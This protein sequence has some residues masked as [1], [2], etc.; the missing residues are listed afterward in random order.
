MSLISLNLQ[1]P[2]RR[3]NPLENPT[4]P[5]GSHLG[6]GFLSGYREDDSGELVNPATAMGQATINSCVR[7]ISETIASMSPI[8]YERSGN[9]KVEA[10][11]NPLHKILTLEPSPDCSAFSMWDSFVAS[12]ALWGNGYLEIQRDGTGTILGLHFLPPTSVTPVRQPDKTIAYRVTLGMAEGTFRLLPAKSIC[13]VPWHS[14]DGV[15]GISV[16]AQARN[17]IGSAIAM[18]KYSG[19]FWANDAT[20]SGVL[21]SSAKIKPEDKLKMRSD[22][23]ALNSGANQHKIAILDSDLTYQAIGIPNADSEWIANMRLSR[24]SICGLFK[25]NPSQIGDTAR[26]AGE[27]YGAQQLA[28]LTHTLRPWLNRIQQELTRKLIPGLPQYSIEHNVSDLLRLDFKSQ[29]D[30][31]AVA[32]QWGIL[33]SNE[34]REQL[35]LDPGPAECDT[36]W[37][38]ANMLDAQRLLN[39]PV[40]T[41]VEGT[42]NV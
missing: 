35:G 38:P 9:G 3:S 25:V 31:F 12:I 2:E 33:T 20:P 22:W 13:H 30:S 23:G 24:E 37:S 8:L 18:D 36:F 17:V 26:V 15:S 7:L 10:F 16:I 6:W 14:V 42:E 32:R 19:R 21:K 29:M 4:V 40:P 27:T 28:W 39:P 41:V 11:D 34:C 1:P 5:L